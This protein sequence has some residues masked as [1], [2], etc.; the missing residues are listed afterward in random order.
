MRYVC[1]DLH[2]GSKYWSKERGFATPYEMDLFIISKLK[3]KVKEGDKLYILGD[4]ANSKKSLKLLSEVPG[5][6]VLVKGNHDV[7][8]LKHYLPYFYDIRA[9]IA[10]YD[11]NKNTVLLSHFPIHPDQF[12]RYIKNVHGHIHRVSD[13]PQDNRYFGVCYDIRKDFIYSFDEVVNNGL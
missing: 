7:F 10:T 6:K 5:K 4:V 8:E 1:S 9:C 3:E 12:S 13:L 2:L 11:K